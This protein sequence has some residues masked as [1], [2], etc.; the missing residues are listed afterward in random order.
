MPDYFVGLDLGQSQDY[1]ALAVLE[2]HEGPPAVY[3]V[4]H[5]ERFKLGTSYPDIVARVVA[6]MATE[7]LKSVAGAGSD[8]GFDIGEEDEEKSSDVRLVV[9]ATG[10]GAP[11]VDLLRQAGLELV[12]I[13][14]TS[15]EN[16]KRKGWDYRVPKRDLV[17]V[18]QV[19]FQAGRFKVAEALPEA[20]ILVKELL[21]FRVKITLAANDTYAAWREGDHD[22]LVL[23]VALPVW[24]GERGQTS[25][26][27]LEM[28]GDLNEA[29]L[30]GLP[31][32]GMPITRPE[33]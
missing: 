2:K 7:P 12:A 17:G 31:G 16:W 21:A 33:W 24:F 8:G 30:T 29:E 15:G 32:I 19:V 4:R 22:D 26:L 28:P 9:D 1:T 27:D 3:H 14:I 13:T 11:V 10:V 6:L 18:L 23:A 25:S 5:L 20:P